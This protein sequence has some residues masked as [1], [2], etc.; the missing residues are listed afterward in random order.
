MVDDGFIYRLRQARKTE[1][2]KQSEV[3]KALSISQTSLSHYETGYCEPDME[4]I[5]QLA[6]FYD[7][8][9]DWLLG[10]AKKQKKKKAPKWDN[11]KNLAESLPD[12]LKKARKEA[13]L[14]QEKVSK[15]LKIP[16]STIAKYEL[17]QLQPSLQS[18]LQLTV[19][20]GITSDWLLGLSEDN[21]AF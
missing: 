16:Q 9:I 13:G 8:S 11:Q 10:N 20:Y 15:I 18:L 14:S 17:G 5:S 12:K 2:F 7:V 4:T 21:P 6:L 19:F 1:G 3:A